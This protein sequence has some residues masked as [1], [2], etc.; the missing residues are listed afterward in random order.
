MGSVPISVYSSNVLARLV[1]IVA[2]LAAQHAAFAHELW[3]LDGER[4][5]P[6]QQTLCD[7]HDALGAVVGVAD[8][9]P[10]AHE[11]PGFAEV[12]PA[13]AFF[14][15]AAVGRVQP[16]SRGPPAVF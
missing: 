13:P 10:A 14:A 3:H 5:Q 12:A 6:A 1:L 7:F 2:L 4:G 16:A 15:P 8:A 11:L 9:A